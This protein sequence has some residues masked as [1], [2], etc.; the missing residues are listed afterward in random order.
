MSTLVTCLP[1]ER[2][3][4]TGINFVPLA[5]YRTRHAPW[6]SAPTIRRLASWPAVWKAGRVPSAPKDWHS[7]RVAVAARPIGNV[8]GTPG[9]V[10]EVGFL[11]VTSLHST[12]ANRASYM[13]SIAALLGSNECQRAGTNRSE[14]AD[15][16][17]NNI[18]ALSLMDGPKISEDERSTT[19]RGPRGAVAGGRGQFGRFDDGQALNASAPN[20]LGR[21]ADEWEPSFSSS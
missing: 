12:C 3:T 10:L 5:K 21:T 17:A 15:P 2:T 1:V 19:E 14:F 11:P 7:G 13:T 4:Q 18:E 8:T 16:I 9:N 6:R 20:P